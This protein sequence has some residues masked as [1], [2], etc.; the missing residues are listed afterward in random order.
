M[1]DVGDYADTGYRGDSGASDHLTGICNMTD[2]LSVLRLLLRAVRTRLAELDSGA[3]PA[4]VKLSQYG[5]PLAPGGGGLGGGGGLVSPSGVATSRANPG[6]VTRP[7]HSKPVEPTMLGA[8]AGAG[9]DLAYLQRRAGVE[10]EQ[11]GACEALLARLSKE[12]QAEMGRQLAMMTLESRVDA[13]AALAGRRGG[14]SVHDPTSAA[15]S[16]G[17]AI[18]NLRS[19]FHE[20]VSDAE[21]PRLQF[22]AAHERAEAADGIMRMLQ[23]ARLVSLSETTDYITATLDRTVPVLARLVSEKEE[24]D[25]RRR[26]IAARRHRRPPAAAA[27]GSPVRPRAR[28]GM[29]VTAGE[30]AGFA[31]SSG[32]MG[33][34]GR[35]G[36]GGG[37]LPPLYAASPSRVAGGGGLF[38][39][40]S[41]ASGTDATS[42]GEDSI[43]T[44]PSWQRVPK[45]PLVPT[46]PAGGWRAATYGRGGGGGGTRRGGGGVADDD[47][48]ADGVPPPLWTAAASGP[49]LPSPLPARTTTPRGSSAGGSRRR[50]PPLVPRV[51]NPIVNLSSFMAAAGGGGGG[52]GGGGG[53]GGSS[54]T[55]G[56]AG[57]SGPAR[58]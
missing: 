19:A 3:L 27:A 49:G 47:S 56:G 57:R 54:A 55:S 40:P 37:G 30:R 45:S 13:A 42:V 38:T 21:L 34:G 52:I 16:A 41:I 2:F 10:A 44:A 20:E 9:I 26:D 28:G 1:E 15:A 18:P 7:G 25:A 43:G 51:T 8:G 22:E 5:L 29:D 50:P 32:S 12:L 39:V 58:R 6:M 33:G 48:S 11:R 14:G 53:G 4:V 17:I 35:G 31:G 24:A 36:G 23:E 46:M